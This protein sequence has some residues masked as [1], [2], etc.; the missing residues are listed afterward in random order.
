MSVEEWTVTASIRPEEN[1][2]PKVPRGGLGSTSQ[3]ARP[4]EDSSTVASSGAPPL[5]D[6]IRAKAPPDGVF[7]VAPSLPPPGTAS[8]AEDPTGRPEADSQSAT[9]T[10]R[11]LC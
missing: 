11:P 3:A 9:R 7:P 1:A 10:V 8:G 6:W 5:A 2:A 4:A